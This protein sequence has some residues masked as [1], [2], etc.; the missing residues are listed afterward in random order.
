M[1]IINRRSFSDGLPA[2]ASAK[3]GEFDEL[4]GKD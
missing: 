3:A 1:D 4:M 2:I